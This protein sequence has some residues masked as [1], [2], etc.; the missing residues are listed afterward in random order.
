MLN[1]QDHDVDIFDLGHSEIVIV[2]IER[3]PEGVYLAQ[4]VV[5]FDHSRMEWWLVFGTEDGRTQ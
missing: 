3:F 4:V 5:G 1:P 2:S